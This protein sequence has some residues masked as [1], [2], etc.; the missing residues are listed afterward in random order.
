MIKFSIAD[1]NL[2]LILAYHLIYITINC[3]SVNRNITTIYVYGRICFL[4]TK[5]CF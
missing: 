1:I 3:L 4:C 5:R 2:Y